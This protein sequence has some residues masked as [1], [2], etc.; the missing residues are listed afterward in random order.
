MT[1]GR[2]AK[3][4]E[5]LKI[6]VSHRKAKS[7]STLG[8]AL[9]R[10][11]MISLARR[12]N[13]FKSKNYQRQRAKSLK[14]LGYLWECKVTIDLATSKPESQTWLASINI[15]QSVHKM[16]SNWFRFRLNMDQGVSVSGEWLELLI[17]LSETIQVISWRLAI[18]LQNHSASVK[19]GTHSESGVTWKCDTKILYA[20]GLGT[21]TLTW[22]NRSID[23]V[24]YEMRMIQVSHYL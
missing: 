12:S 7:S 3:F 18:N 19:T 21:L 17:I 5:C 8:S 20:C 16:R 11:Q 23:L 9:P 15:H 13:F 2:R 24:S 22:C 10:M 14:Y 1:T 6:A 4:V